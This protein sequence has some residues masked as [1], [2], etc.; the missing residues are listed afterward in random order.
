M[1]ER[2]KLPRAAANAVL[3]AQLLLVLIALAVGLALTRLL[4]QWFAG[5]RMASRRP[6]PARLA[7]FVLTIAPALFAMALV[8]WLQF[9]EGKLDAI[10][11]APG[12]LEFSIWA[13]IKAWSS[14]R[15]FSSARA[16]FRAPSRVDDEMEGLPCHAHRAFQFTYFLHAAR[17][18][19]AINA[20]GID[21]TTLT[22]LTWSHGPRPR[23]G[24][25]A[26][27]ANVVRS[28]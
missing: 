23:P 20:A 28:C 17:T 4:R 21:L 19:S 16:W 12:E 2:C 11:L 15:A 3:L 8:G 27:A 18:C 7:E 9:I 5:T 1:P 13:L 6:W 26:I 22:V 14:S 24:L 25:Q 10:D